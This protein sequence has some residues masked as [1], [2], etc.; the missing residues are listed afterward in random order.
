[1]A[2]FLAALDETGETLREAMAMAN[3]RTRQGSDG[4]TAADGAVNNGLVSRLEVP[5]RSLNGSPAS[6]T[7]GPSSRRNEGSDSDVD[8]STSDA[9]SG[10]GVSS[11]GLSDSGHDMTP[12]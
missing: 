4:G 9:G 10:S 12:I 6:S 1:L 11:S 7:L 2:R 3:I 8:A 5:Q